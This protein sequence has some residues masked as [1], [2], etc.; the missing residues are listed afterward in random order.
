MLS[1]V[2][3]G[4]CLVS[5]RMTSKGVVSVVPS[6][7]RDELHPGVR[8]P[9]P[10]GFLLPVQ[11]G[12]AAPGQPLGAPLPGAVGHLSLGAGRLPAPPQEV[13]PQDIGA[14]RRSRTLFSIRLTSR[15]K[16]TFSE[17]SVC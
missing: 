2:R 10:A 8:G 7:P 11:L 15:F 13:L 6:P 17:L 1:T 5:R 16:L 4:L 9:L 12:A 14:R 3:Y